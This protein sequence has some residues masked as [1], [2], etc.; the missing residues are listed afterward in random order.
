MFSTSCVP[1]NI[2]V[3]LTVAQRKICV[4][5]WRLYRGSEVSGTDRVDVGQ[6]FC[7]K[8]TVHRRI[9]GSV[10]YA[11]TLRRPVRTIAVPRIL[12]N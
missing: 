4:G 7:Q 1:V 6:L 8:T 10:Y 11:L 3:M 2:R 9:G 5:C 12:R